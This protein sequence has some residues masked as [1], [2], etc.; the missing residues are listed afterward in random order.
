M[1]GETTTL[2]ISLEVEA[3]TPFVA[4]VAAKSRAEGS[5]PSP[6]ADGTTAAGRKVA[7]E[8]RAPFMCG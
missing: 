1:V 8:D 4:S 5:K 2:R 7:A 3:A 6:S